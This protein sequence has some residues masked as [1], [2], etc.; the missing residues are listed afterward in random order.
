M[1]DRDEPS[2]FPLGTITTDFFT[3][4]DSRGNEIQNPDL[5]DMNSLTFSLNTF[6]Q[7]NPDRIQASDTPGGGESNNAIIRKFVD[8][9][10]DVSMFNEGTLEDYLNAT[11][12]FLAVDI[13]QAVR[14]RQNYHEMSHATQ[15]QRESVSGVSSVEELANMQ[16]F[17]AL[18]N[19]NARMMQA[20]N[21]IY[22]TL[23]NRL[24]V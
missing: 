11:A 14:F 15:N 2:T 3:W 10:N 23:I 12:N 6:L 4:N 20:I 9:W 16:R 18:F 5:A 24:G 21:E 17:Q 13:H 7:L 1:F 19:N 22:D 8:L